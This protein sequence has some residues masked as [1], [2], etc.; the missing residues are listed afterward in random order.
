MP[1]PCSYVDGISTLSRSPCRTVLKDA[2]PPVVGSCL[3]LSSLSSYPAAAAALGADRRTARSPWN[4]GRN[5]CRG[6]VAGGK[7]AALVGPLRAADLQEGLPAQRRPRKR[8]S[9]PPG[10]KRARG[11]RVNHHW[12]NTSF[13]GSFGG[14]TTTCLDKANSF[15][16]D[17]AWLLTWVSSKASCIKP[18]EH[19]IIREVVWRSRKHLSGVP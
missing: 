16:G 11:G 8:Q 19:I 3:A 14:K 7:G 1:L 10:C 18:S 13:G 15:F 6:R 4:L 12:K 5:S 17:S 9:G 2:F